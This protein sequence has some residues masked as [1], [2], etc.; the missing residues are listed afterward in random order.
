MSDNSNMKL[1]D[2]LMSWFLSKMANTT[3]IGF[4][5]CILYFV[6][7]FFSI[8]KKEPWYNCG[9]NRSHIS[10]QGEMCIKKINK[11][12]VR[13]YFI[14]SKTKIHYFETTFQIVILQWKCKAYEFSIF[15][16]KLKKHSSLQLDYSWLLPR[17]SNFQRW[18]LKDIKVKFY[19]ETWRQP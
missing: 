10:M 7:V 13:S 9:T 1:S 5:L 17:Q 19:E 15:S 6:L 18:S 14:Y 3:K 2:F 11:G 8:E 4:F 12:L 16:S